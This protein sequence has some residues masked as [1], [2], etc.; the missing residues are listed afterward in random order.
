MALSR[1]QFI[2]S[3]SGNKNFSVSVPYLSKDHIKVA[4]NGVDVTFTWLN[5]STVQLTTAPAVG[6]VV[7]IRRETER[8]KLLVN[9]QDASTIT[10]EQLD[11]SAAQTFYI[12]QE[13]FDATGGTMAQASDG[14][15]SAQNRRI[16]QL[17]DP[18]SDDDAANVG[19]V[20]SQYNSGYD[21]HT[22][23]VAAESAATAS[24]NSATSSA[25]SATSANNSKTAAANSA[26]AAA[27]SATAAANSATAAANSATSAANSATSANAA[28]TDVAN[29]A[30]AAQTAAN[31]AK[32]SETNALSSSNS[33]SANA[34]SAGNSAAKA[35]QWAEFPEDSMVET[36]KYSAKHHATKAAA[37][38]ATAQTAATTAQG[39]RDTALTHKNDA[40]ASA[41]TATT[42][43]SEAATSAS[44]AA[45]KATEAAN[46]AAQAASYAAALNMPSTSGNANKLLKVNST[47]SAY[48]FIAQGAGG[49]LVADA[50]TIAWKVSAT[51][52]GTNSADLVTGIMADNDMFRI[53]VGGSET[54]S[55][56]AEI[57]T[58]DDGTEPI[59][60]RQYTGD[61]ATVARTLTL[62]DASGNSS[63]PGN[64]NA[65]AGGVTISSL[66][67]GGGL[68][69]GNGDSASS[70]VN[71]V[72]LQSWFGIGFGPSISGQPVPYGEYSHWFNVR[73]GDMGVRGTVTAPTFSG[74]LSGNA[75]T[76]TKLATART[77]TIAGQV[78]GSASF[79]GSADMT[80]STL[81]NAASVASI[82]ANMGAGSVGSVAIL[83]YNVAYGALTFGAT[84]A[85]SSLRAHGFYPSSSI[86]SS[87]ITQNGTWKCLSQQAGISGQYPSGLFLRIS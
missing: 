17:G 31:N 22:E 80:I 9:F 20:K 62:L 78:T 60:V 3:V 12:A 45:T 64:V 72:K 26:T 27:N 54:N 69:N 70:T 48:E 8:T 52:T 58:A 75:A 2:Q 1:N 11:L 79:D 66:G 39:Y 19:W 56:W 76:A 24:A 63:F 4:V 40:A 18:N 23:R 71:N 30:A 51:A 5:S 28:K 34:T 29:N 14:S 86:A 44:T 74:S 67:S 73:T 46:S 15:Y 81:L 43:A 82:I 87:A 77:I 10:E 83:Q 68:F 36:G 57:A 49:G 84:Y 32:T 61:F 42:K 85:G 41:A 25:S 37:S 13:A 38:A 65:T 16:S 55:G 53:R 33:A 21:A 59:Y 50:A 7:D 6:A 47:G 35:S